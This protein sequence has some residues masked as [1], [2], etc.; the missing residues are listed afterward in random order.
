MERKLKIMGKIRESVDNI[1]YTK[2][3]IKAYANYTP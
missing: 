3:G 1:V 2:H